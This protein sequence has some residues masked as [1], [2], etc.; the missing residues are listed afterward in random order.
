[1]VS[2][3][4]RRQAERGRPTDILADSINGLK[5]RGCI[6]STIAHIY[7]PLETLWMASMAQKRDKCLPWP[8]NFQVVADHLGLPAEYLH[9]KPSAPAY[10]ATLAAGL[11]M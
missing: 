2:G 4:S 10:G 11:A 9:D 8:P 7:D 1:M 6:L 5:L 3:A